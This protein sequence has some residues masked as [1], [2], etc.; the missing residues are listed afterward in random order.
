MQAGRGSDMTDRFELQGSWDEY[1]RCRKTLANAP[2][3]FTMVEPF[4]PCIVRAEGARVWDVDGN[5]YV[6]YSMAYG[7]LLF[8]HSPGEILDAVHRQLDSGIGYGRSHR[9]QTELAEAICRTVPSAEQCILSNTGSEAVHAAIRIARATTRRKR[10]VK[11]IGHYHGWLDS[12]FVGAPG[13]I[14]P[15][16]GTGGQD[17]GA[18]D[19]VTVCRWNDLP[20]LEAVMADDV[21]AVIMEPVHANG[22]CL[23]PSP[24][25][26]EGVRELTSKHGAM[27]IFDEVVTG[28]RLALGGAQQYFGVHPDLTVI[29]KALGAGFPVSAV[30]GPADRFAEV[31]SS[32]VVHLGTYN[33]NVV[34]A[35]AAIAVIDILERDPEFHSRLADKTTRVASIIKDAAASEGLALHIN[36]APGVM[37]AFIGDQ[38]ITR[39]EEACTVQE[40]YRNFSSQLV[41]NGVHVLPLGLMYVTPEHGEAELAMTAEGVRAAAASYREMQ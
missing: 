26:L 15:G 32:N 3:I 7:P 41:T 30:C 9:L 4:P 29:G 21:A 35:A 20:A 18:A 8:G 24:G 12:I 2:A 23:L 10:I 34:S 40:G 17:P 1:E 6:D 36:H 38:Q 5:C 33:A 11:F 37:H 14:T 16:P 31:S 19:T 13:Q 25:Y 22:G 28:Y 27:L 39:Y